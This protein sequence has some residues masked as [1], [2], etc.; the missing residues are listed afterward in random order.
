[1]VCLLMVGVA[2]G[3][4]APEPAFRLVD[5]VPATSGDSYSLSGNRLFLVRST[6]PA[7]RSSID[8]YRL[9]DGRRLW[10]A[11]FPAQVHA[12]PVTAPVGVM[13]TEGTRP[14][15]QPQQLTA[16]DAATG[17]VLWRLP[18]AE[19]YERPDTI[20]SRALVLADL[21]GGPRQLRLLDMRSGAAV[22]SRPLPAGTRADVLA[23]RR[24]VLQAPDG[25]AQILDEDTG[26]LLV[27]GR[28][29]TTSY[30]SPVSSR[31]P[32]CRAGGTRRVAAPCS[33]CRRPAL[34]GW[35]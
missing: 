14:Q 1:M 27:S 18:D 11:R 7:G 21:S 2:A 8:A 3:S 16:L 5:S 30:R 28:L 34:S 35:T 25:T 22:W 15:Q 10:Q 31:R 23:S 13:L 9:P 26:R 4:A 20:G 19:L 29:E 24:L 33:W 32:A 12:F 6:I 17:R